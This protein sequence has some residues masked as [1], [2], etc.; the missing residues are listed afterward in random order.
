MNKYTNK[1]V[2]E[3]MIKTHNAI[4]I[5]SIAKNITLLVLIDISLTTPTK[6]LNDIQYR[7]RYIDDPLILR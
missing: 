3:R 2:R 1:W 5:I 6:V 4:R 7:Y